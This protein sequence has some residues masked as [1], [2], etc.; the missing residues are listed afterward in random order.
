MVAS[1]VEFLRAHPLLLTLLRGRS[2]HTLVFHDIAHTPLPT[3]ASI[4]PKPLPVRV[5]RVVESRGGRRQWWATGDRS[6]M[7]E[8]VY[9]LEIPPMCLGDCYFS[10]APVL[11]A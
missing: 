11:Q 3:A 2:P 10:G 7:E 4:C 6:W 5:F 1:G 9:M 8:D